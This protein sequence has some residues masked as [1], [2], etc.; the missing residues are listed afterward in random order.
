MTDLYVSMFKGDAETFQQKLTKQ[1]Q[2]TISYMDSK[3]TFYHGFLLGL[4]ANLDGYI[5]KSNR[6]GGDG[7]YD[8][9][10]YNL[11]ETIP[12]V[13]LELKVSDTFK[14]MEQ[15]SQEALNQIESKRYDANLAEDGYTETIRYG[16]A[17]FKKKCRIRMER[18]R[19][20]G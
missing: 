15:K 12:P 13:I 6:E 17:F 2:K 16:I 5:I 8:I 10:I 19:L 3:E 11:D 20:E 7:R 9:C 18:K 1:L 14:E 4:F